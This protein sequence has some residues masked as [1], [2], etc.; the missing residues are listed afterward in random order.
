MFLAGK[1][2]YICDYHDEDYE[3]GDGD[4][5]DEDGGGDGDGD[6]VQLSPILSPPVDCPHVSCHR[7]DSYNA[8]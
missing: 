3:D 6:D 7:Q 5:D 4:E 2:T 1:F 8:G